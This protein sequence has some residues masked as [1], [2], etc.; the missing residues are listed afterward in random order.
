MIKKNFRGTQVVN[1]VNTKYWL[2]RNSHG[3]QYGERGYVKVEL[4]Y[5]QC[6]ILDAVFGVIVNRQQVCAKP[7]A[8]NPA[9]P[10]AAGCS[11]PAN[12]PRDPNDLWWD[13][14]TK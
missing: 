5:A 1:G 7:T 9:L 8:P 4:G 3:M 2:V 10:M 13:P 6:R 12:Y 14:T 11:A